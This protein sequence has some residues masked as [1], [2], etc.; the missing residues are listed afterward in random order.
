MRT[1]RIKPG[2]VTYADSLSL[3]GFIVKAR[4]PHP[5]F[6][7]RLVVNPKYQKYFIAVRNAP[8]IK[9]IVSNVYTKKVL[10][11]LGLTQEIIVKR[12][13]NTSLR[14]Q[15]GSCTQC[16]KCT[17]YCPMGLDLPGDLKDPLAMENCVDCLYCFAVCPQEAIK[18]DGELGFYAE[19]MRRY[20]KLIKK[21][22]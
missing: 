17:F 18:S 9:Q 19:Q 15:A 3:D 13:R 20:G 21:E 11:R 16:G 6:V 22:L 2:M 8:V 4:R 10:L 14:W 1:G 7:A 12:E 5:N